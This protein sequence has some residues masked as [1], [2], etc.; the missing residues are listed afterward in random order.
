MKTPAA[1]PPWG[2]LLH[3]GLPLR[4]GGSPGGR[5]RVLM[6]PRSGLKVAWP[7]GPLTR[8]CTSLKHVQLLRLST[9]QYTSP[10]AGQPKTFGNS[11]SNVNS[12]VLIRLDSG[13][14][15]IPGPNSNSGKII[16]N[17]N[18]SDKHIMTSSG[19]G[20]NIT[21]PGIFALNVK[22]IRNNKIKWDHN[23]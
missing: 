15:P 3:P 10:R 19:L 12:D 13:G 1:T 8:W 18:G 22:C 16:Y 11:N 23:M 14:N 20:I 21:S 5:H 9:L 4:V 2:V 7:G 6:R 17:I